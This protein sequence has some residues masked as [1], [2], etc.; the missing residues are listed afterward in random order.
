MKRM[1]LS[2]WTISLLCVCF[3]SLTSCDKTDFDAK[4]RQEMKRKESE[5]K[6]QE[7]EKKKQEEE[8]K[9]KEEEEKK[10]QE[11]EKKKQE[12]EKKKKEEKKKQEEEKKRREEEERK[13]TQLVLDPS[14]LTLSP[15]EAKNV[16][17]K[18]GTAPY[19]VN[20]LDKKIAL[21]TLHNDRNFFV[22]T[23]LN[24][25]E[26]EIVVTDKNKKTAKI[27][28]KVKGQKLS[29]L[30][31][32]KASVGLSVG[33]M[34]K[35]NIQSGAYPYKA[36]AEDNNIVKVDVSDATIT[37]KALK[38]GTTAVNVS[39]RDGRKGRISVTVTK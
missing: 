1:N 15:I 33:Q 12:E 7:E 35:V 31:F 29:A 14:T 24:G 28:V 9:K 37:I 34:E 38:V 39:D 3:I 36:S 30:K 16:Y 4:E 25:G 22:V 26:T 13:K 23:G 11:E 20:A 2:K 5:K 21:I 6:K 27:T 18:N 10:K 19:E 8:K 32:S 17:I